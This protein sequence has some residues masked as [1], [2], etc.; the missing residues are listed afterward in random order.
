MRAFYYCRPVRSSTQSTQPRVAPVASIV[1]ICLTGMKH[2]H[3]HVTHRA[4]TTK[5]DMFN[6]AVLKSAWRCFGTS[7]HQRQ[8]L[9][10]GKNY[11]QVALAS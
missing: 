1:P 10:S 5:R 2:I 4:H 8:W 6:V 3:E 7:H 9:E 11:T